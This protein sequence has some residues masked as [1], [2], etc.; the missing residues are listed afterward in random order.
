MTFHYPN[1]TTPVQTIIPALQNSRALPTRLPVFAL[2]CSV[3][4]RQSNQ[5]LGSLPASPTCS[6][7][8]FLSNLIPVP[9]LIQEGLAA[10][11]AHLHHLILSSH[12]MPSRRP[13]LVSTIRG[14]LYQSL[15]T[16]VISSSFLHRLS[17]I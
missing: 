14:L 11:M 8:A 4:P 10:M 5:S 15:P 6:S 16:I 9:Y 17:R 7:L 12:G 2:L 1:T 3:H 13:S